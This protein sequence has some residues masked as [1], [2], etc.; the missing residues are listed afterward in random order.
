MNQPR[1]WRVVLATLQVLIGISAVAG[2]IGLVS[3]PSGQNVGMSP[4]ALATS[5]FSDY[6]IP[7]V[8]LLVVNGGGNLLG[9]WVSLTG[10]RWCGHA[11]IALG[12]FLMAWITVQ[13]WWIGLVHWLQPMFFSLGVAQLGLGIGVWR[14]SFQGNERPHSRRSAEISDEP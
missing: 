6:L 5:P 3:D 11:A 4:A 2:G 8:V 1:N 9:G 10:L 13:V 7:G 12:L 14:R